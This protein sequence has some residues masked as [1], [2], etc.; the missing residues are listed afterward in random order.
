IEQVSPE[1][2][3]AAAKQYLQRNNRT[4]GLFIPT[5]KAERVSVPPTP[6]VPAMVANYKGR[7]ALAE[8]EEFDPTPEKI[9]ARVKRLDLPEGIK[10]TLL[11]KKSRGEEARLTLTLRYG[12]EDTLKGLEPATGFLSDLMLRG[13]KKLSYQQFRDELDRLGATLGAGF[14]GGRRGGGRRGGGGGGGGD[15]L[16][17][18]VQAKR[19]TMPAVIELLRQVLRDPLM[20][21]EEFEIMKRERVANLEQSKTEPAALAPRLL[22]RVLNPYSNDDVRYIP[23]ID[24]SIER[25]KSV[26]YEQ[27]TKLYRDYLGSQAGELTIVGDFDEQACL[28]VL[29]ETLAG[30]KAPTPYA[31]IA[32]PIKEEVP[33]SQHTINTPDKAN[34]TFTAG[35]LFPLRDDD[36]DYPALVM[37]NYILGGGTL[38]SRLG[39]RV[40]QKEGLSYGITSSLGVSSQDKRGSFTISAIVNPQNLARLQVCALEEVERLLRDGVTADELNKAREG[41]LQSMKV[42]RSSDGG[43]A[44]SLGNL[45]HLDRTML[46]EADFE[47]KIAALTPEQVGAAM[48]RHIDPKKLVVVAAGDFA[49]EQKPGAAQ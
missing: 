9:E 11:P 13:T 7:A 26:T 2:V 5:E 8:G 16:S 38:S 17:F 29:K 35:L 25:A 46:W 19:D 10:A 18:S 30:W 20:P 24:E 23:T 47:K 44:G 40:R 43:L 49:D 12:T 1:K 22:Q 32:S 27:V 48:K 34:A 39:V 36:P 37:G 6:D 45:R 15:S 33:A 31:R 41:Y 28:K 42:G 4:V 14:G 21:K 3:Q